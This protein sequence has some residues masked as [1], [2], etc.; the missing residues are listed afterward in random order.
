MA[1]NQ[2]QQPS[3]AYQLDTLTRQGRSLQRAATG[4]SSRP[5]G[6]SRSPG[7][8]PYQPEPI[9]QMRAQQRSASQAARDAEEERRERTRALCTNCVDKSC[10]P[11]VSAWKAGQWIDRKSG[12]PKNTTCRMCGCSFG[13]GV[14]VAILDAAG[15]INWDALNNVQPA[16]N[17]TASASG[18][19]P[20]P[21][22]QPRRTW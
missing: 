16:S 9:Q 17:A 21:T 8:T 10:R 15:V 7:G 5:G 18:H 4:G 19:Q 1:Y 11:C 12:M 20:A 13:A 3:A 2:P 14:L 22:Y 6:S